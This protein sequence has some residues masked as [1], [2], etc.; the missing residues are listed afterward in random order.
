MESLRPSEWHK[1]ILEKWMKMNVNEREKISDHKFKSL[2]GPPFPNKNILHYG[3]IL[4]GILKSTIQNYYLMKNYDVDTRAGYDV[5]GIPSEMSINEYLEINSSDD[6]DINMYII[7]GIKLINSNIKAWKPVY[8]NIA[9]ITNHEKA[10]KTLDKSYMETVINIFKE[11]WKRDYVYRGMRV[12]PYSCK[13][14][15]PLSNFEATQNYQNLECKS[16]YVV[17]PLIDREFSLVAWTTTCWTL[18]SNQALAVNSDIE[19]SVIQ[20][21]DK[22]YCMN[23][24]AFKK[25]FGKK[26]ITVLYKIYGNELVGLEYEPLFNFNNQESFK[27]LE[28]K[29]VKPDIEKKTSTCVVHLSPAYGEDDMNVCVENN[30]VNIEDNNS[31]FL[32]TDKSGHFTD[33]VPFLY[34]MYFSD[35]EVENEVIKIMKEEGKHLGTLQ[36]IHNYPLCYRTDTPLMYRICKSF[37]V[38][39]TSLK[40]RM[41]ELNKE[42]NW[43]PEHVGKERFHNWLCNARDWSITRDRVFGTPIPVWCSD[44][45]EEMIVIGSI[46]ELEELSGITVSDLHRNVLDEVKIPSKKNPGTY[47]SRVSDIFDCWFESGVCNLAQDHY[48][49]EEGVEP[50]KY[51]PADFIVEG[52]DQT[53]GWFY[54]QL[55]IS[56]ALF[57]TIPYKNVM[58]AGLVLAE[59]GKKMS[60]RLNNFVDPRDMIEKYG[61][62]IMRLYLAGS[63]A[64]RAEPFKFSEKELIDLN[65]QLK[66]FMTVYNFFNMYYKAYIN[67]NG[68]KPNLELNYSYCS[69]FDRWIIERTKQFSIELE[70]Q[71]KNFR[72]NNMNRTI[73][74]Y[75]DDLANIYVKLNRDRIKGRIT[76]EDAEL[77]L[78]VLYYAL[79]ISTLAI[80]PVMPFWSEYHYGI[81]NEI[82]VDHCVIFDNEYPTFDNYDVDLINKMNK[83]KSITYL[84]RL[85]RSTSKNHKINKMPINDI[86]IKS[87]N[88]DVL[89]MLKEFDYYFKTELN[90]FNIEYDIINEDEC[91]FDIKLNYSSIGTK[92]KK[93]TKYMKSYV[94]KIT[95]DSLKM[96]F[97]EDEINYLGYNLKRYDDYDIVPRL[98]EVPDDHDYR[99]E[100]DVAIIVNFE[101]NDHIHDYGKALEFSAKIQQLRKSNSLFPSDD[102]IICHDNEIEFSFENALLNNIDIIEKI[103]NSKIQKGFQS[104]IDDYELLDVNELNIYELY[105]NVQLWKKN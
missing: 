32:T 58:C 62:D 16:V 30:I 77:S 99:I 93:D 83:F 102:V 95:Q 97:H 105:V 5:H 34:N 18:P 66:P 39:V 15:T 70:N 43:Q 38:R 14:E 78:S 67:R 91:N 33:K 3:H 96:L 79:N 23:E 80:S 21:E 63:L 13:C 47:L 88:R 64:S 101:F 82:S 19:Y 7:E 11:L 25:V 44:D 94:N 22:K 55:V 59:D 29:F 27:V 49:F 50:T 51:E 10:Y 17:Y 9:R 8:D 26:K 90:I 40:D 2:D 69:N 56:T 45:G 46:N 81:L 74:N 87:F 84:V 12:L 41:I 89:D 103:S 37:F 73:T 60:K 54:T 86:K 24:L 98:V 1:F 85:M 71:Y 68:N 104:K 76:E 36:F 35:K 75:I 42:I 53:R 48:M 28:G 92:M 52:I 72:F 61:S 31:V 57:D 65:K 4:I 6:V 20:Y 100:H